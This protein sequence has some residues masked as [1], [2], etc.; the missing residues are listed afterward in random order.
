MNFQIRF[1]SPSLLRRIRPQS[2]SHFPCIFRFGHLFSR[3]SHSVWVNIW[4]CCF[5]FVIVYELQFA[6]EM[7]PNENTRIPEI[8]D[9]ARDTSNGEQPLVRFNNPLVICKHKWFW[10]HRS[11]PNTDW[12]HHCNWT[13]ATFIDLCWFRSLLCV[14]V[15]T[16]TR[17]RAKEI[18]NR[19]DETP[20]AAAKWSGCIKLNGPKQQHTHTHN[21][22]VQ[23]LNLVNETS[24]TR[25]HSY[26]HSFHT[27]P[28]MRLICILGLSL[29]HLLL[30]YR[31]HSFFVARLLRVVLSHW[32]LVGSALC[33][34]PALHPLPKPQ[35]NCFYY[36]KIF[37]L[38]RNFGQQT[39]RTQI[40]NYLS[41]TFSV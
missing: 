30:G 14:C 37:L 35:W 39:P 2:L 34:S 18:Q 24:A 3:V 13:P 25:A 29:C 40:H 22:R 23:K 36:Y 33:F 41:S 27:H 9:A 31:P 20:A 8:R 12:T 38:F 19:T 28:L 6:R 32:H 5:T 26:V 7:R 17:H 15:R 21:N 1:F 10:L 4:P 11:K 16:R